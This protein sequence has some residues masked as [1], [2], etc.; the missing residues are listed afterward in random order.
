MPSS[1]RV[2]SSPAPERGGSRTTTSHRSPSAARAGRDL[3][4]EHLHLRQV[5]EVGDG[6]L[7]G[8]R[9]SLH[10]QHVTLRTDRPREGG[11]ERPGP[12]VEVQRPLARPRLREREHGLPQRLRRTGVDLPEAARPDLEVAPRH[13]LGHAAR[14]V[15]RGQ[16][17]RPRAGPQ[18]DAHVVVQLGQLDLSRAGGR[19]DRDRVA[20]GR[21]GCHVD[22]P[23]PRPAARRHPDRAD[24]G[25]RHE[26]VTHRLDLGRAVAVQPG[27]AVAA[28]GEADTRAPAE[29]VVVTRHGRHREARQLVGRDTAEPLQLLAQDV[30]LQAALR[31]EVHVLPVAPAAPARPGVRAGR[32]HPLRRRCQD[33]YGVCPRVARL[34]V[35]QPRPDPLARQ[36]VADQDRA[37]VGVVGHA[38][39][40]G[41]DALDVQLDLVPDLRPGDL[42][43]GGGQRVGHAPEARERDVRDGASRSPSRTSGWQPPPPGST[44][45][46]A[47]PEHVPPAPLGRTKDMRATTRGR[48]TASRSALLCLAL[49][50]SACSGATEAVPGS[51]QPSPFPTECTGSA[52]DPAACTEGPAPSAA[53]SPPAPAPSPA[54]TE[55]TGDAGDPAACTEGP[56]P[57]PSPAPAGTGTPTPDDLPLTG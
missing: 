33:G 31:V 46:H 19:H 3:G 44:G 13:P 47:L 48:R 34:H 37:A 55:C 45:S 5:H 40:A 49:A 1:D 24:R 10:G 53:P 32:L 51:S 41:C 16:P 28:H 21:G 14:P 18:G 57:S 20:A 8:A 42:G 23:Y 39:P 26:A 12:G 27:R 25:R 50:L 17:H 56:A 35:R 7:R 11:G 30:G 9:V 52:G 43:G 6:V 38:D 4:G 29:A 15:D 2:S 36:R 54:P 22:R